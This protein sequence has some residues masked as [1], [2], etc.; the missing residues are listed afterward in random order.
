MKMSLKLSL[1][2][3][4]WILVS[5]ITLVRAQDPF[6]IQIY[7]YQTVPKGMWN[8]ETHVNYVGKGTKFFEGTVAPSHHQFHLTFELTHGITKH[9]ETAGYLVLAHR[10]DGGFEYVGW[11]VRPRVRLPKSWGLPVD[12]SISG[13]V[14]FPRENYDENSVTLEVRPIIEK[15]F[16]R[17]QLDFNPV[18]GRALQGP[19]TKEG[20]D[21]EPGVRFGYEMNKRL[22]LSLEYYGAI[23]PVSRPLPG[24]EQVHQFYPGGDLMLTENIVWNFGIGVGVTPVGNRLVY[25]SRIGI[26][27]GTRKQPTQS[28]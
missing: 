20:W 3:S 16:G 4:V 26:L 21:F 22:D 1:S 28:S 25:K 17:F 6:E 18:I 27:F 23:G 7:E 9:F 13:E 5:A 19:G 8:L 10:P 15:K 24:N 14:G 12:I 11:R 2:L